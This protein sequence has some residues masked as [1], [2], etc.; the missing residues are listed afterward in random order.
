VDSPPIMQVK[1]R[2]QAMKRFAMLLSFALVAG[3][4]VADE[5]KPAADSKAAAAK[6]EAVAKTHDVNVQFVSSDAA[7]ST[8]TVKGED[9][10]EN[11]VPVEGKALASLKTLKANEKITVTCRDNDKGEHQAITAVK[12]VAAAPAAKSNKK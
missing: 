1:E 6:T 3:V 11:T 10:K 7:K 2:I 4:A 12:P 9:G 8:I 5:A